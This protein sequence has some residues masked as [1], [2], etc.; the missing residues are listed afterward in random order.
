[1][2]HT[3][4]LSA[5]TSPVIASSNQGRP[6]A[7]PLVVNGSGLR[8]SFSA[9]NRDMI[10]PHSASAIM[11]SSSALHT[12]QGLSPGSMEDSAIS[13]RETVSP[14]VAADRPPA[15]AN[16][17]R[18]P[19]MPPPADDTS[20]RERIALMSSQ[21]SQSGSKVPENGFLQNLSPAG[22]QRLALRQPP[23]GVIAP[24]DLAIQEGSFQNMTIQDHPHL[25]PVWETQSPTIRRNQLEMTGMLDKAGASLALNTPHTSG[26][27]QTAKVQDVGSSSQ[28]NAG[29]KDAR[30]AQSPAPQGQPRE[31][32]HVRGARSESD[33]GWQKAGKGK[34]KAVANGSAQFGQAETL[35]KSMSDRKGG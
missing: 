19:Q 11:Q 17:S 8:T 29:G 32:G 28:D 25:S 18:A 26:P 21:G 31:N 6:A 13:D 5:G 35:P 7:R 14:P 27:K 30:A 3:R 10:E 33:G 20:F 15:I 9:A 16:G 34:K 23:N 1:M 12:A 4:A 24:L 22:R 2:G